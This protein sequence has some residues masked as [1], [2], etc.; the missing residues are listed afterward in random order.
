MGG[1]DDNPR[2]AAF[3][4]SG[5]ASLSASPLN[6]LLP[7]AWQLPTDVFSSSSPLA[8]SPLRPLVRDS[9]A[10]TYDAVAAIGLLACE[11]APRGPLP[12]DFGTRLWNA[13]VGAAPPFDGLS[14][15]VGFDDVGNR[16]LTTANIVLSNLMISRAE[17]AVAS[18]PR[19]TYENGAWHWNGGSQAASGLVFTGE[20]SMP[21]AALVRRRRPSNAM[22]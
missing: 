16:N 2:W 18:V 20:S 17:Q 15:R 21:P 11:V 4:A 7:S 22:A 10:F 14:G 12:D 13:A 1:T 5:W 3:E 8:S 6:A 19:A 9:G